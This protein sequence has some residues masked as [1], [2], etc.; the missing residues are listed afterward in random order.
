VTDMKKLQNTILA[1]FS[2]GL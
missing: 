2:Q 1:F